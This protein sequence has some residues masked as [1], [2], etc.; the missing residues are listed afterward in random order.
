M[1]HCVLYVAKPL[2]F[3]TGFGIVYCL[4]RIAY[5]VLRIAYCVLR[6]AYYGS[7]AKL[8][9]GPHGHAS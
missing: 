4:L 1:C 3:E 7:S 6:I 8:A 9:Y 5:C 2:T